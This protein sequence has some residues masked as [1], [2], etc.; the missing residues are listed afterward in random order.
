MGTTMIGLFNRM[1]WLPAILRIPHKEKRVL[2]LFRYCTWLLTSVSYLVGMPDSPLVFKGAV[3]VSLYA[4]ARIL[5]DLYAKVEDERLVKG[6]ALLEMAGSAVL[7]V[8]TL[9]L[10]SPF[11]WYAFNPVLVSAGIASYTFCWVNL[12]LYISSATAVT[13]FMDSTYSRS[14]PL[15]LQE[16][17]HLFTVFLLLTLAAQMTL[18]LAKELRARTASLLE[19][20]LQAQQSRIAGEMHDQ[21]AQQLFSVVYGLK[22]LSGNWSKLP[23]EEVDEQLGLIRTSAYEASQ[24]LRRAIYRMSEAG[25]SESPSLYTELR[26]SLERMTKLYGVELSLDLEGVDSRLS[27]PQKLTAGRIVTEAAGNA[28]RHGR[29]STLAIMMRV[30]D[31]GLEAVIRDN[32]IGFIVDSQRRKGKQGLGLRG[33][34]KL[35]K[36]CGGQL[37]IQSR[38]SAG[39]E[40]RIG[41]PMQEPKEALA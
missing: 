38:L 36:D 25:D 24:E 2:S 37:V 40:V 17:V 20:K 6:M 32:G 22:A 39:T 33:M 41:L 19:A 3:V 21:V 34:E 4:A 18:L 27:E 8:P 29:C 16:N 14:L 13:Y 1:L 9:G 15:I 10:D 23:Q 26:R 12:T 11:L 30:T 5:T 31:E 35:I 7:L 28:I